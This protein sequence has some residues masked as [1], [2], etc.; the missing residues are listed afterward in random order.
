VGGGGLIGPR[1]RCVLYMSEIM[2]K[3]E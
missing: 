2:V 3:Y 1:N